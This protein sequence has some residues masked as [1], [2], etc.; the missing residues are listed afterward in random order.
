MKLAGTKPRSRIAT[1]SYNLSQ[2]IRLYDLDNAYPQMFLRAI[3]N[4]ST[5]KSCLD[6]YH[7]FIKGN[8]FK[9]P[10]LSVLKANKK[11]TYTQLH[12]KLLR[13]FSIFP[14]FVCHVGYNM[15]LEPVAYNHIP[16]E[17]CRWE[18]DGDKVPTGRIA[19]HPDWTKESGRRFNQDDIV[20]LSPFNP[21]K[22]QVFS[23]IEA[24]GGFDNYKGQA[25]YACEE[26]VGT[27]PLAHADSICTWMETEESVSTVMFRNSRFNFLPGGIITVKKKVQYNEQ[28]KEIEN[29]DSPFSAAQK[30]QGDENALKMLVVEIEQDEDKPEF[31]AFPS[32]NMD[33]QFELTIKVAEE[34]I[35]K[36]YHIPPVLRGQSSS[37]TFATDEIINAY[38]WYNSDTESERTTIEEYYAQLFAATGKEFLIQPKQYKATPK[39]ATV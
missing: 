25:F 14:A 18:V 23:E 28:G 20:Y 8:G 17:H 7:K 33:K 39:T 16:F 11:D 24:C 22:S 15:L 21:D 36:F 31:T 4:S 5:A 35:G 9:D 37:G 10:S 13:D 1:A 30:F 34:K 3:S 29:E 27:Y 2:K 38:D 26:P 6:I 19:V 12:N 32:A